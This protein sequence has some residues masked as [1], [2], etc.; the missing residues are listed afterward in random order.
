MIENVRQ[1]ES[2]Q[3][4]T[5]RSCESIQKALVLKE[6]NGG[7]VVE[8]AW[9]SIWWFDKSYSKEDIKRTFDYRAMLIL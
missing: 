5:I 4:E 2:P 7:Y 9:N 8:T 6:S 1:Y 3:C